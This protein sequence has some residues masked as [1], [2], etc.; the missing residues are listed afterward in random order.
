MFLSCWR[1]LV[2][3]HTGAMAPRNPAHR[4]PIRLNL[5]ALEERTTPAV[6][7][8]NTLADTVAANF[9]TGQD[10]SGRV[11]LRSAVQAAVS[12]GGFEN[13]ILPAAAYKLT[14]PDGGVAPGNSS[15][16][17]LDLNGSFGNS[18]FLTITGGGANTT[19]I[20]AKIDNSPFG[21]RV[22]Q[23]NAFAVVQMS[24]VT[25]TGGKATGFGGGI[26]N[27]GMLD[28][29][30]CVLTGNT[31]T[32]E[33]A[34]DPAAG[35][36]MENGLGGAIYNIGALTIT[37]CTLSD[38][39]AIGGQGYIG[40]GVG[41]GGGGGAGFGGAIF[42]DSAGTVQLN[43]ATLFDNV[44][45][46]GA[47]GAGGG[48]AGLAAVGGNGG[49]DGGFGGYGGFGG[50]P[51]SDGGFGE[52][53]GGGGPGT[54]NDGPGTGG[55]AGNG[56][57][58]GGGGGGGGGNNFGGNSGSGFGGGGDGGGGG[59]SFDQGFGVFAS[60]VGGGGGGGAGE[61]GGLFDNSNGGVQIFNSTLTNNQVEGGAGGSVLFGNGAEGEA[62]G[63]AGGGVYNHSG[64]ATTVQNT[65]I[66]ANGGN[67]EP[68]VLGASSATVTTSSAK[69]M[70][71]P[72]SA[73]SATRWE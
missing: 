68:D 7:T 49:G 27:A 10:A 17:T 25:I 69:A 18:L 55:S 61:G 41:G 38:N 34:S 20:D 21:D 15:A 43:D 26:D 3:K 33:G 32:G 40:A 2:K 44:A 47:G 48:D 29:T 53:G 54:G 12:M 8:V 13:I 63:S 45:V 35:R 64:D 19:T 4:K 52:G 6:F 62:G 65:I 50:G 72:A 16:G 37:N 59:N 46:G 66:A 31:A 5:E 51:G 56:G 36:N 28:L 22:F 73:A 70:V 67:F 57:F 71:V 58:G 39:Q 42:N 23:I 11:S 9:T 1:S 30:N 14:I 24:G 60:P